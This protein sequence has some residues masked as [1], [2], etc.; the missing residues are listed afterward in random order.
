MHSLFHVLTQQH[1][2]D[3]APL[4]C[5]EQ[6]VQRLARYFED[7]VTENKLAALVVEGRCLSGHALKEP[8]RLTK[9]AAVGRRLYLFCCDRTCPDR[10]W[11]PETSARLIAIEEAG[12]HELETGPFILVT[13]PR[14]CGLLASR[15]IDGEED[16]SSKA[17]NVVW[18][19]DPNVVFTAIEYLM[20]RFGVQRPEERE[21]FESLLRSSTPSSSSLRLALAFTTKLTMLMQRQNE[22]EMATNRISAAIS[23][24]LEL[25]SILQSAVEEVGRAVK[26]RRA[27]LVLWEE[28]TVSPEGMT[29]YE[30]QEDE[31]ASG[32]PANRPKDPAAREAAAIEPPDP[33]GLLEV[34]VTYRENVIGELVVEH[35]LPGRNWEDEEV[36]M[37]KTVSDQL[38]V[39]ISHARLFRK[40]EKQAKTDG[41]T[42]LYNHGWFQDRLDYELKLSDRYHTQ[43]SLILLDLD[44]LKRINDTYGHVA[45]DTTLCHVAQSMRAVVREVD[46]CARYG[47]EEFCII[48]PQCSRDDALEVAERIRASIAS[49]YVPRVGQVTASFGVATY[50]TDAKVKEELVEMADRA[51]YLAK[52]A[53]RNRVRTLMH[54]TVAEIDARVT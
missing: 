20:A 18:T 6:S 24:T 42:G 47:G 32:Q 49:V 2:D 28:G 8:E 46:L 41:L 1:G 31:A 23:S 17:F 29:I 19:F 30:R 27:A 39:A 48:L 44:Q 52:A 15:A 22:L 16:R 51:M 12:H 26:A 3:L 40:M 50:P 14:F 54:R 45:G 37:V 36:L 4:R 13:E 7:L 10:T 9:L 25:E 53:G 21:R 33:P 43:V 35:D 11:E 34:P 5:N 38:A